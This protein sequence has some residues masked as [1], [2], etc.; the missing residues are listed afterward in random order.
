MV[1]L[2]QAPDGTRGLFLRPLE[3]PKG[4]QMPGTEGAYGPFFSPDGQ[5]VGFFAQGKLKKTRVDGGEPIFLCDAPAGRGGSRT[6]MSA[7]S[8]AKNDTGNSRTDVV[9]YRWPL[10]ETV[11]AHCA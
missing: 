1:F 8:S 7:V 6:F 11:L 4:T 9:C 5:W 3:Q 2:S 10:R